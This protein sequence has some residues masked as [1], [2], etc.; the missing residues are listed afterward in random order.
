MFAAPAEITTEAWS[1]VPDDLRLKTTPSEWSRIRHH[2]PYRFDC[3]LEGPCFDRAGNL[4]VT[5]APHGRVFKITPDKQWSVVT[6]YDGTPNGMKI[7]KD[8]MMFI[9]DSK[10]GI[11][12][13]DPKSGEVKPHCVRNGYEPFRGLNDLVFDSEG[14]LYFTDQSMTD[15]RDPTGCVYR[16]SLDGRLDCLADNVPSPNGLVLAPDEKSLLLAVTRANCIWHLPFDHDGGIA[17]VGLFIQLSG[18][19]GGGPDGLAM[20]DDGNLSIAHVRMGSVWVFSP[21]GEPLYRIRSCAGIGTTNLAYGGPDRRDLY[22]TEMQTGT[23]LLA[24]LPVPGRTMY[25]HM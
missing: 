22:I 9:A 4:Y 18:S 6:Q 15:L 13:L 11:M 3:F 24:K 7:R 1:R 19:A 23:I 14:N 17:R 10:W 25:S 20:D 21:S 12:Q 16:L 5:D 8:G 2:D